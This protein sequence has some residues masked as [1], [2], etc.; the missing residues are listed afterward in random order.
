MLQCAVMAHTFV[1]DIPNAQ[2]VRK[3]INDRCRALEFKGRVRLLREFKGGFTNTRVFLAEHSGSCE[4]RSPSQI[5]FK[6]GPSRLLREETQRFQA[7]FRHVR[8]P[9]AFAHLRDP[10]TTLKTLSK[11]DSLAAIAYDYA[12]SPHAQEECVSLTALAEQCIAGAEPVEKVTKIIAT[13][14]RALASA[15]GNPQDEFPEIVRRYYL[16]RW[17]PDFEVNI[18]RAVNSSGR[19]LLTLDRLNP[20]HSESE[21]IPSE[22]RQAAELP[23]R[24]PRPEINLKRLRNGYHS[25]RRLYLYATEADELSIEVALDALGAHERR[26]LSEASDLDLWAPARISRYE[27]YCKRIAEAFKAFS[28]LDLTAPAFSI[29]ALSLHNPLGHLSR[30]LAQLTAKTTVGP[31]HGDLHPGNVMVVGTTPVIIDY[32]LSDE[33]MPAGVDAARL[34]GG[35]VRG[36]FAKCLPFEELAEVLSEALGL[37]SARERSEGPGRRVCDLLKV[38]SDERRLI[39]GDNH[40]EL[41]PYHLYGLGWIGLKWTKG[42]TE[43]YRASFLLS[44]VALTKILGRPAVPGCKLEV[45]KKRQPKARLAGVEQGIKPEG[46]AE[47]LVLVAEFTGDGRFDATARIYGSLADHVHDLIPGLGRVERVPSS[48]V[49]RKDAIALA[50]SYKA[51]MIVWGSYDSLGVSPRYDVTRDS[52]VMKCAWV[53][54]D[55]A[56]RHALGDRFEP[57]LTYDLQEE[58]SFLSLVAIG[59]ICMLN[60]NYE[61]GISV[62]ESAVKLIP[63]SERAAKLGADQAYATLSALLAITRRRKEALDCIAHARRLNESNIGYQLQELGLM[64]AEGIT[65][66]SEIF[67]KLRELLLQQIPEAGDDAENLREAIALLENI[68]TPGDFGKLLQSAPLPQ[69]EHSVNGTG[70]MGG[71]DVVFHLEKA[72]QLSGKGSL[73]SALSEV[74]KALRIYPQSP[75]AQLIKASL[76]ADLGDTD[77][78]RKQLEKLERS[79]PNLPGV[80]VLRGGLSWYED[81]NAEATLAAYANAHELG[82]LKSPIDMARFEALVSLGREE[83][84]LEELRQLVIDPGM[85]ETFIARSMCYQRRGDLPL[86]LDEANQAISLWEGRR[87]EGMLFALPFLLFVRR[88]EV[89]WAKGERQAAVAD[90]E[91]AASI[92]GEY[93]LFRRYIVRQL[94]AMRKPEVSEV[95]STSA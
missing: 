75:Q 74:R 44:A 69:A 83:E 16:E 31:V 22:L 87:G 3:P 76:I 51:S 58:I 46:P 77:A 4:D 34:F 13:V 73:R 81:R 82:E 5:V 90:L 72:R 36:P 54:L 92:V 47:I 39:C 79:N 50:S 28:N 20:E 66:P 95:K 94:E 18:D 7:F 37:I 25:G 17:E 68:K 26:A 62:L 23:L 8:A 93:E 59:Q 63:D 78:A 56:T 15:R 61:A 1:S 21:S 55:Q 24:E 89:L 91:H 65:P 84:V 67:N 53:Q 88:G 33:N 42:T 30:P 45:V 14:I 64:V 32:G 60:L 41:W 86:A 80:Y 27:S 38:F 40:E 29:G 70:R 57:Y 49:S 71:R 48:V 6:T 2:E 11:D 52:L 12:P 43:E 19:W 35:L 85:P 9:A 10:E